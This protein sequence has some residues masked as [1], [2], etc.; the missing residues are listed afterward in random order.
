[1]SHDISISDQEEPTNTS[2]FLKHCEDWKD[3]DVL[4]ISPP[5]RWKE[6][7]ELRHAEH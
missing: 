3:T 6:W 2:R 1:M 7:V 5:A 4:Y